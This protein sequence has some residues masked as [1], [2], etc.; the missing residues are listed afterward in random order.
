MVAGCTETAETAERPKTAT[1]FHRASVPTPAHLDVKP[2][3]P[4]ATVRYVRPNQAPPDFYDEARAIPVYAPGCECTVSAATL[5][6]AI[7]CGQSACVNDKLY[8]CTDQNHVSQTSS[9]AAVSACQC[10]VDT[11]GPG[12]KGFSMDCGTTI[13]FEGRTTSCSADGTLKNDQPCSK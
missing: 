13:C 5:D 6:V 2:A 8:D 4:P 1:H 12:P 3:P 11:D 7:P 10:E 9:C